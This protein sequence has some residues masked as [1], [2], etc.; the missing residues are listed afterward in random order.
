MKHNI[1]RAISSLSIL[2]GMHLAIVNSTTPGASRAC[3][4]GASTGGSGGTQASLD[5]F[6]DFPQTTTTAAPTAPTASP[7]QPPTE[8]D[9]PANVARRL[10][11]LELQVAQ[12][13]TQ[14]WSATN[15]MNSSVVAQGSNLLS[16]L[17]SVAVSVD[18]NADDVAALWQNASATTSDIAALALST[19][20][21]TSSLSTRFVSPDVHF[22][23]AH[24]THII[25]LSLPAARACLIRHLRARRSI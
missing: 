21:S 19:A 20:V 8:N 17:T 9:D 6:I 25:A 10:G 14:L 24:I 15:A 5:V 13:L 4:W 1:N 12:Q 23:S 2:A 16:T 18:D 7:T 22:T 3:S 11:L